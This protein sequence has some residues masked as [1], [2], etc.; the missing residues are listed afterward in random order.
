MVI[1]SDVTYMVNYLRGTNGV[2]S[3]LLDNFWPSADANGDCLIIGSDVTRLI[4]H[5]RGLA[6]LAFCETHPPAWGS[7]DDL[8]LTQPQEWPNC[9]QE[10]DNPP[11][12]TAVP[13]QEIFEGD[14]LELRIFASDSDGDDITLLAEYLPDNTQ[15]IDS[16]EGVGGF[17]FDPAYNQ[18]GIY[19]VRFI[20][21][22]TILADTENVQIIVNNT[23]LAPVLESIGNRVILI[24]S[25]HEFQAL[26]FDPDSTIP[27]MNALSLPDSASYV[28]NGDGTGG[29]SWTPGSGD[30]GAYQVLFIASDGELADSEQVTITVQDSMSQAIIADHTVCSSWQDIPQSVVESVISDFHIYYLHTSH[31]SQ[32]IEGLEM[33]EA[34]D[35]TY[36][37]PYFNE[38]WDDLGNYG[39]TSWAPGT[40]TYL[41]GHP[42]CNI[43]MFSWCGGLTT[44]TEAGVNIY[45]NKLDEL[46]LAYPSVDF[47]YMTGHMDYRGPDGNRAARNNQIR[48]YCLANDRVLFDFADIE[49][50]DPDGNYYP[51][52][53]DICNW[54]TDWCST[55]DCPD[56]ELCAHSH[57]FNCY[58]KGKATWWMLARLAGWTPVTGYAMPG[59]DN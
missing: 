17:I 45:L 5:F 35:S 8:P 18:E 4:N 33:I 32:L 3:C 49:S 59:N 7:P 57:C 50:Y 54:C 2:E 52:E 19:Q 6:P 58:Q 22:S 43:A 56:C 23:N 40:R 39:D 41:D 37:L 27:I 30:V 10:E 31:G 13:N 29:F 38:V 20:A 42:E 16:T 28:D 21:R 44:N 9:G 12:L 34:E 1:G 24:D 48:A 51:M 55:H 14:H 26:A 36:D 25:L 15:F 53:G 11:I 46:S 47:I